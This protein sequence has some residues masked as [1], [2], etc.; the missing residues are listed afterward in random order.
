[1][2]MP[3]ASITR[4][5][6]AFTSRPANGAVTSRAAANALITAIASVVLTPKW[7][8]NSGIAGATT[9]KPT[10]TMNATA[11][12]AP[13]SAGSSLN[14][15]RRST[16][17]DHAGWTRAGLCRLPRQPRVRGVHHALDVWRQL[18]GEHV[19]QAGLVQ[20]PAQRGPHR[21]PDGRQLRRD[22]DVGRLV[23]PQPAHLGQWPVDGTDHLPQRDV[24][25]RPGQ[26]VPAL[27]TALA[28][29]QPGPAQLPQDRLDELARQL[30]L[31]DD[32]VDLDEV[33]GASRELEQ[34]AYR[35]VGL[36]RDLHVRI[37]AFHLGITSMPRCA[38]LP[39][40]PQPRSHF[41]PRTVAFR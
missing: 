27:G 22:A 1:M 32:H 33:R 29:H 30:L 2:P 37:L 10:A 17:T 4:S 31:A 7:R 12:S 19:L 13:T 38:A 21:H 24:A 5:P 15:P 6:N 8:A 16:S 41:D 39:T 14:G 35:V 25:R 20:H 11:A 36:R 3:V 23:G 40:R 18:A 28:A 34:G 9:P 26:R